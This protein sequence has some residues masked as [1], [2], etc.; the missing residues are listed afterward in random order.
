MLTKE[1]GEVRI[2][3]DNCSVEG[4]VLREKD[5]RVVLEEY[6]DTEG[7]Q[8][9]VIQEF[10]F[11]MTLKKKEDFSECLKEARIYEPDFNVPIYIQALQNRSEDE[12]KEVEEEEKEK[13]EAKR[14]CYECM[15]EWNISHPWSFTLPKDRCKECRSSKNKDKK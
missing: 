5:G 2:L 3:R 7:N 4:F 15:N 6:F 11:G 10:K 1:F 8:V 14:K 12:D 13:E 9:D